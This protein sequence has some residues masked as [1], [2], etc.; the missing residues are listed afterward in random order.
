MPEASTRSIVGWM[1]SLPPPPKST[2]SDS[3]W[4]RA[5]ASGEPGGTSSIQPRCQ[6]GR[7]ASSRSIP[8]TGSADTPVATATRGWR[9]RK[10]GAWPAAASDA[11]TGAA[12][13]RR[14]PT[15]VAVAASHQPASSTPSR[16]PARSASARWAAAA[17]SESNRSARGGRAA[18][19]PGP[20][21]SNRSATDPRRARAAPRSRSWTSGS[22]AARA[23]SSRGACSTNESAGIARG[24]DRTSATERISSWS[25][26]ALGP[27]SPTAGPWDDRCMDRTV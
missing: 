15:G 17:S 25:E 21:A 4:S 1:K 27:G 9:C 7:R 6:V 5:P 13:R 22:R 12:R 18:S 11:S 23:S 10:I 19:T 24:T 14:S 16:S 8:R 20:D 3:T 26:R 2:V